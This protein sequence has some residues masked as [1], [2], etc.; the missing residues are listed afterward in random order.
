[1]G[2]LKEIITLFLVKS[3]ETSLFLRISYMHNVDKSTDHSI[4]EGSFLENLYI[5]LTHVFFFIYPSLGTW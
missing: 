2:H 3:E 1:M 5:K 4:E